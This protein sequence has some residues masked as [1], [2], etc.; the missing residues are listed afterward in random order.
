MAGFFDWVLLSSV[1]LSG[2]QP[3]TLNISVLDPSGSVISQAR[4]ILRKRRN[5]R[6]ANQSFF[7]GERAKGKASAEAFSLFNRQKGDG[8]DT[9]CGAADFAGPIPQRFGDGVGS[10]AKPT[11]GAPNFVAPARQLQLAMWLNF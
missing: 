9:V 8:I 3:A 1:H 5:R 2:Q 4:I 11:S 6:P 10:P 7:S